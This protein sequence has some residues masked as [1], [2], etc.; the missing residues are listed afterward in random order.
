MRTI[1]CS[2]G[3]HKKRLGELPTFAG[4][5]RDGV[6][7]HAVPFSAPPFT[8]VEFQAL[9]TDYQNKRD[10]YKQGGLGQKGAFLFAKSNLLN[11][12]DEMA[13]YVDSV[14]LGDPN[15]ITTAGFVPTKG[16]N[17]KAPNPVQ[18]TGVTVKRESYGILVAECDKQDQAV[19]YG[20]IMTANEP[21]PDTV[22]INGS[23]QLVV[24]E[25]GSPVAANNTAIS[26]SDGMISGT[27]DLN[28]N[29]KKRFLN[30]IPGVKYY[31]R[32]YAMNAQGVSSLS[33]SV[34]LMC[35]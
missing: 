32:F 25:S 8:D 12:L 5:V 18:P 10:I 14:A 35:S 21:L 4:G 31:F 17:S 23:G 7:G 3:Y 13:D 24:S 30:L 34:S 15:I 20:C 28:M 22:V 1:K 27:F 19:A 2:R 16:V 29:R 9:I 33:D 26:A 11:G 6:Y